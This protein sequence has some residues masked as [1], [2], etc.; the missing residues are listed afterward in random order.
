MTEVTF[1]IT[2]PPPIGDLGPRFQA[3]N[4]SWGFEFISR[5]VEE[6]LSGRD[7]GEG[8][9]RRSGNLQ[10]DWIAKGDPNSVTVESHGIADKYAGLQEEGGTIRPVNAKWLWIPLP[11]NMTAAG[12]QRISPSQ[13]IANGGFFINDHSNGKVFMAY[14]LTKAARKDP[15]QFVPLFSLKSEVYVPPRMGA[16]NLFEEMLPDLGDRLIKEVQ[17]AWG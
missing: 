14:P 12:V 15:T 9:D 13:A 17:E 2:V 8:L 16:R 7:H 4:I 10:R 11:D 6:R 1:T 3:A 5:L